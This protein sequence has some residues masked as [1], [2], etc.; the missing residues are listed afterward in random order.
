MNLGL[1]W[2]G[3]PHT[4]EESN[5]MANFYPNLYNPA[6][7]AVFDP[8]DS[9]ANTISPNSPGLFTNTALGATFYTNGIAKCGSG[10]PKGCVGRLVA[11]FRTSR[12][13][14][15]RLDRQR[16]DRHS[17]RIRRHV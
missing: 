9:S 15:L 6:N 3:I 14:R 17:W 12:R 7:A 8:S 10:V 11:Q 2:D 13:I 1:R 16:Q 4:Y 5:N